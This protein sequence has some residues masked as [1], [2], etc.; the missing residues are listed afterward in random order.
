M[1]PSVSAV[2]FIYII[3]DYSPLTTFL[4][5]LLLPLALI[6]TAN[7]DDTFNSIA[8]K[9]GTLLFFTQTLFFTT[10][11]ASALRSYFTYRHLDLSLVAK[12]YAQ[13]WWSAPCEYIYALLSWSK[14][15]ASS[16]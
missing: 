8:T 14:I 9:Q 5:M 4:A 16:R 6:P 1:K 10:H 13:E 15:T 11:L 2:N 12:F 3:R 7:T